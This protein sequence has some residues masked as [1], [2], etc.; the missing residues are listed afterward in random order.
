[1]ERRRQMAAVDRQQRRRRFK[2]AGGAERMAEKRLGGTHRGNRAGVEDRAGGVRFGGVVINGACTM[3]VDVSDLR[4][5]NTRANQRALDRPAQAVAGRM[6]LGEVVRV[7]REGIAEDFAENRAA[8]RFDHVQR[9]EHEK[10]AGFAEGHADAVTEGRARA[11]G[12]R[13]E[14]V[15]SG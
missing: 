9:F 14:G 7:A 8:A 10:D 2:Q 13:A 1:M 12:Q 15:E 11:Y 6:G 5:M 4:G 3:R